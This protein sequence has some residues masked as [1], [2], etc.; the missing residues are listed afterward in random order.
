MKAALDQ[1]KQDLTNQGRLFFKE[2]VELD[3]LLSFGQNYIDKLLI[4]QNQLADELQKETD[5]GRFFQMIENE[6]F[7]DLIEHLSQV[8]IFPKEDFLKDYSL[9]EKKYYFAYNLLYCYIN[10]G[11][12]KAIRNSIYDHH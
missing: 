1:I 8:W 3:L 2:D 7:K 4:N 6:T 11:R 9:E 12:K 10:L 5:S